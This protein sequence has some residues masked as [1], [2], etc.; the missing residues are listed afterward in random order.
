[1]T[2]DIVEHFCGACIA[3]PLMM[4]GTGAA[5]T[6]D[7]DDTKRNDMIFWG[8]IVLT[9]LSAIVFIYYRRTCKSCR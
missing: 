4:V 2:N 1:M 9:I 6:S 8:G 7:E 5:V 3:A